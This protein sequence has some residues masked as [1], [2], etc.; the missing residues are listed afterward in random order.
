MR[1]VIQRVSRASVSASG[2]VVGEIRLGLCLFVGVAPEDDGRA[3]A[4]AASKTAGMRIF[5]DEDGKMNKSLLDVGG[6]ALVISQF[7]LH[8]DCRRGR[9]PSFAGAASPD[10]ANGLYEAFMERLREI[11][12]RVSSGVF[13]AEMKVDIV[14]EGPVTI[15]LDT[16]DMPGS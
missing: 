14:N 15:I 2:A 8:A 4:W 16:A 6:E 3:V 9:R 11:G 1:I 5:E 12:V 13:G 10:V 7:T